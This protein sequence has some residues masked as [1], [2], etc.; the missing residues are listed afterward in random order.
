M[1][2]PELEGGARTN[3][4]TEKELDGQLSG[5]M[6]GG[7]DIKRRFEGTIVR[8][9]L[10]TAADAARSGIQDTPTHADQLHNL[11]VDFITS[12]LE[13]ALLFLKHIESI[14]LRE[15]N[16][17]GQC[18]TLGSVAMENTKQLGLQRS[19]IVAT[20]PQTTSLV[21][22]LQYEANVSAQGRRGTTWRILHH[23][24][25]AEAARAAVGP[26]FVAKNGVKIAI[27]NRLTLEK[28]YP[29]VAIAVPLGPTFGTVEGGGQLFS[30]LPLP[31]KTGF[32][33]H[34]H[35]IFALNTNRQALRNAQ[36]RLVHESKDKL[37]VDWK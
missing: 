15:I 37:L 14:E 27:G 11:F 4:V 18:K 3:F 34:C 1:E 17:D 26:R 35:G 31:I 19:N 36:E 28:L 29:H 10:R 21:V 25:N 8:L 12:E 7:L 23:V 30:I 9:P 32:K 22:K 20:Q 33:A 2:N 24:L 6:A 5:Y 16:S 13:I